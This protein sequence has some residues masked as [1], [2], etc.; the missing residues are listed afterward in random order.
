M[1]GNS[2]RNPR[3]RSY[4]KGKSSAIRVLRFRCRGGGR[5][6]RRQLSAAGHYGLGGCA[7]RQPCGHPSNGIALREGARTYRGLAREARICGTGAPGSSLRD[8]RL[9]RS[10]ALGKRAVAL[11]KRGTMFVFVQRRPLGYRRA[12]LPGRAEPPDLAPR[13]P[14]GVLGRGSGPRE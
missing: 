3:G 2:L 11:S 10:S 9:L 13:D 5:P 14:C 7:R 4:T 8:T 12:S 6:H 1:H